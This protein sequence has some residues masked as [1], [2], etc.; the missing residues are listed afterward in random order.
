[1]VT[2]DI[3]MMTEVTVRMSDGLVIVS[4]GTITGGEETL[5]KEQ[6][7]IVSQGKFFDIWIKILSNDKDFH[8]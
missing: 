4:K 6:W 8:V 2:D 3:N 5:I 7:V 1:M